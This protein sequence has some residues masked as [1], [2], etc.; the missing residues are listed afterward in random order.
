M[1]KFKYVSSEKSGTLKN[2]LLRTRLKLLEETLNYTAHFKISSERRNMFLYDSV[3]AKIGF[4][5]YGNLQFR[6][7]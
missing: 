6:G 3:H 2:L 4:K 7:F 5:V 1:F